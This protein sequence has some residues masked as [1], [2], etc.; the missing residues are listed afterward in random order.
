[1]VSVIMPAY[2]AAAHIAQAIGSVASQTYPH[3]EIVVVDDGST[4]DTV[5][6]VERSAIAQAQ[7]KVLVGA[8]A[9]TGPAR[10]LAIAHASGTILAFLDSD[11]FWEP[12]L[13]AAQVAALQEHDCDVVFS[14]GYYI[15]APDP[16]R[17]FDVPHGASSAEEMFALLYAY[18]RLP[19][20]AVLARKAAVARTGG[21][22][23]AEVTV[24][25]CEDY[26]FWLRMADTGSSFFGLP[27]QL[28]GIRLHP[29]SHVDRP[30]A[31]REGD[32]AV[33]TRFAPKMRELDPHAYRQRMAETYNSLAMLRAQAGDLQ[34][35]RAALEELRQFESPWPVRAKLAGVRILRR[36]YADAYAMVLR[37]GVGG[38]DATAPWGGGA[39]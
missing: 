34:G 16:G 6:A 9:G 30:L 13:L 4:D 35:A 31:L 1:L 32:L 29:G 36:R 11:D 28:A 14:N 19:V 20:S 5:A 8:H 12:T 39:R 2:N 26:D 22:N 24:S 38:P 37:G 33:L 25:L 18:N 17:G 21:F 23:E 3:W 15:D 7:L 27:E 10:N